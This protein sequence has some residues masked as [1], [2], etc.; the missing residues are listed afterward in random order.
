MWK[1][2]EGSDLMGRRKNFW[3]VIGPTN[4]LLLFLVKPPLMASFMARVIKSI[5]IEKHSRDRD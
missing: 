4:P 1:K 2:K 5:Q 3:D